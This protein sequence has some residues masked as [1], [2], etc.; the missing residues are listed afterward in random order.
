M[1]SEVIYLKYFENFFV[2]SDV[3]LVL[4]L[5]PCGSNDTSIKSIG[6]SSGIPSSL[7]R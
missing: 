1:V 7:T 3:G 4:G 5:L 6:P 2:V